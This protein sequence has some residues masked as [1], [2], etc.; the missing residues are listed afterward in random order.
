MSRSRVAV[1]LLVAAACGGAGDGNAEPP[2]GIPRKRIE[3]VRTIPHDPGAFTQ[4]LEF[5]GNRLFESTGLRGRSS[6]REVAPDTGVILRRTNLPPE[7]FGEGLTVVGD[8]LIQLTWTSGV[9]RVYDRDTF[10]LRKEHA[11]P[12]QGWGL[13]HDGERLVMSD[14]SNRLYFRN[15]ET[16]AL[17]GQVTVTQSGDPLDMLNE[18]ECVGDRVW[19]NVFGTDWI[20]EIDPSSGRVQTAV[21]AS[22]LLSP[23][24]R[25]GTDVLNGIA[26]REGR[27]TWLITGKLWPKMFEIKLVDP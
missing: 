9:A 10:A 17:Q 2:A 16:F 24:E 18:L 12:T 13:C 25:A 11:Y 20:V 4:G 8:E 15:P 6:I 1:A 27:D 3:V 14:G 22:G 19:A 21:D 7:L 5:D 23:S 26:Y